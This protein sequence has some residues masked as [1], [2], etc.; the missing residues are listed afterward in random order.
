MLYPIAIHKDKDSDYGVTVPDLPGCTSAGRTLADALT[1][2]VEAIKGHLELLVEE[3]REIP[4][5]RTIQD[6]RD[7]EAYEGAYL[8]RIVEVDFLAQERARRS[9]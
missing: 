2:A 6:H 9:A 8:W 7:K 4:Q 1:Q 3:N 5:P